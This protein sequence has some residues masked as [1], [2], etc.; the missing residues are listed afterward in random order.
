MGSKLTIENINTK[1]IIKT[2]N[3]ILTYYDWYKL[4]SKE[5]VNNDSNIILTVGQDIENLEK[6]GY[7]VILSDKYDKPKYIIMNGI[8]YIN[9]YKEEILER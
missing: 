9:I 4:I 6:Y 2:N 3:D 5:E 8:K 7:K 1:E